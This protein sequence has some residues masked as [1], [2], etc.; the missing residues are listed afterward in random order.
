M[1]LSKSE[2]RTCQR[3]RAEAAAWIAK[4]HGSGRTPAM[5]R[6]WRAWLGARSENEA[7]WELA[8]EVYAETG[9]L[10]ARLPTPGKMSQESRLPRRAVAMVSV[11]ALGILTAVVW[12]VYWTHSFR[13][14]PGQQMTALLDDGTRVELNTNSRVVERYT[15][16]VRAV[17]LESGEVYFKINPE[18]RRPFVVFAGSHAIRAL[19]TEFV[20]R[21]EDDNGTPLTVTLI[22]GKVAVVPAQSGQ[23]IPTADD[24][25]AKVLSPGQRLR[26]SQN[27]RLDIDTPALDRETAWRQGHLIF[28]NTPLAEAV[29][30]LNRYNTLKL[31]LSPDVPDSIRV[32]G[33]VVTTDM[34]DFAKS[35]QAQHSL[36][37][38]RDAQGFL[39]EP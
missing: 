20:V 5:E 35:V 39:L 15:T 16:E 7:A 8:T 28:D 11:L 2:S 1:T 34:E 17:S 33:T 36:T 31:R 38:I 30:E 27:G 26:L 32:G 19:G 14:A 4:L 21:R 10:P 25:G 22:E 29:N 13:T 3:A 23:A 6:S 18:V 9:D 12:S 24:A 37:L